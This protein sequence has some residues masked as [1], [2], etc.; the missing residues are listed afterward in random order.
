MF[1]NSKLTSHLQNGLKY[2]CWQ[3]SPCYGTDKFMGG[4]YFNNYTYMIIV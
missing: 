2:F 4:Y 1:I 3:I